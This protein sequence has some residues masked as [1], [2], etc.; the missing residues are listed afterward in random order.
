VNLT[1]LHLQMARGQPEAWH[2]AMRLYAKLVDGDPYEAMAQ[3]V[4][5]STRSVR[6]WIA[7]ESVPQGVLRQLALVEIERL[8]V[9]AVLNLPV[10]E[11]GQNHEPA[12][13]DTGG[14]G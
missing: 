3:A 13:I 12:G 6:R 5:C 11:K 8:L 1:N 14:R 2:T 4:G 7:G 10:A 9:P